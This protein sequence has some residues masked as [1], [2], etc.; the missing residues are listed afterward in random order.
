MKYAKLIGLMAAAGL[1]ISGFLPWAYYPDIN[2]TF[3]GFYTYEN[4]YGKP[5]KVLI[6]FAIV[7]TIL[8]LIPKIWAKRVNIFFSALA[9]AYTVKTFA[10]YSGCYRGICPETLYGI[11][12]M[13]LFMALILIA[14]LLPGEKVRS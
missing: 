1:I 9:M 11:W 8:I 13:L 7:C 3:T 5:G 12:L 6:F 2:Q 14:A 4:V 10:M